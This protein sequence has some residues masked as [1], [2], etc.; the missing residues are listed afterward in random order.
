MREELVK[1]IERNKK[2]QDKARKKW[3]A[4]HQ[5]ARDQVI[6]CWLRLNRPG[7][8]KSIQEELKDD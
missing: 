6:G 1:Q 2:R 4:I 3:D 5:A 7:L 8:Y